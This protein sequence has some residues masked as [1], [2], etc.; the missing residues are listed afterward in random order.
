MV[1]PLFGTPFP[2]LWRWDLSSMVFI[3][4]LNHNPLLKHCPPAVGSVNSQGYLQ[5]L[6]GIFSRGLFSTINALSV[7]FFD[8]YIATKAAVPPRSGARKAHELRVY[9][10]DQERYFPPSRPLLCSG[11]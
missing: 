4:L 6:L 7:H 8:S 3:L 1:L 5:V 10:V 2:V 9:G 11:S